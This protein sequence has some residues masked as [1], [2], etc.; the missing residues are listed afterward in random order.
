MTAETQAATHERIL[1]VAQ[2]LLAAKG[3]EATTTRDIAHGAE[4]AVGTLF[5]YFTT[6]EAIVATLA[7]EAVA[8]AHRKF[9]R[10]NFEADSFEEELFA[11]VAAGLRK[12]KPLRQHLPV[13]LETALSPLVLAGEDD[14][15]SLR[16]S[17]LEAVLRLANKHGVKD[18]SPV[19][20][21]IYWSLYTGLLLFWAN[22]KSPRQEDTLALLDHSLEMFVSWLNSRLDDSL[23]KLPNKKELHYANHC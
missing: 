6:K 3:F 16:V 10:G 8:G 23:I 1:E 7:A 13:V 5:N 21:Q 18:L 11:F 17:H 15:Q 19:A 20:L 22:D 4:I 2:E 12:L 9:G 14:G